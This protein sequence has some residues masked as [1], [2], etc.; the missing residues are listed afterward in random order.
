MLGAD[1]GAAFG[2]VAVAEAEVFLG[3]LAAVGGVG[4]VHLKLSDPHQ[5]PRSGEDLLVLR[6]VSDHVAGV[7]AQVALDALAEFLRPFH[8]DLLH[9]EFTEPDRGVRGE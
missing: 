7:L 3:D 5:E 2:D 6:V 4:G 9:P 8:V 1:L